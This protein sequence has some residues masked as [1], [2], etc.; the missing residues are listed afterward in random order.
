MLPCSKEL[1]LVSKFPSIS[2]RSQQCHGYMHN[3]NMSR[4]PT[5]VPQQQRAIC[6]IDHSLHSRLMWPSTPPCS[7][8]LP[9]RRNLP[10][11]HGVWAF[12][13]QACQDPPL[14]TKQSTSEPNC[15]GY[16]TISP[17]TKCVNLVPSYTTRAN[18]PT[19]PGP[20]ICRTKAYG[21]WC[22][23]RIILCA[24]FALREGN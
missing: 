9:T 19:K 24:V 11:R 3:E 18:Y 12:P 6:R 13:G 2:L 10:G 7:T 8:P 1:T 21:C 23:W 14:Q 22:R 20:P 5:R 17:R 15:Q 16:A 4:P